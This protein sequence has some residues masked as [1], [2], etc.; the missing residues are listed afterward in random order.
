MS[1]TAMFSKNSDSC[2]T[3][4][5]ILILT[6]TAVAQTFMG[7]KKIMPIET[8]SINRQGRIERHLP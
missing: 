4:V 5:I 8:R 2:L 6:L 1:I 7:S 3:Q